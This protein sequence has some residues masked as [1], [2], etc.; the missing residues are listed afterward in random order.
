MRVAAVNVCQ[1]LR[2]VATRC[3][4]PEEEVKFKLHR[5]IHGTPTGEENLW[6]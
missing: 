5:V 3:Q 6:Q 1:L 2:S 4:G